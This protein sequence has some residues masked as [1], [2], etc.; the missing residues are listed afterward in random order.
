MKRGEVEHKR[1]LRWDDDV[2]RGSSIFEPAH[3]ARNERK[4]VISEC[5]DVPVATLGYGIMSSQL[6]DPTFPPENRQQARLWV[7]GGEPGTSSATLQ[8]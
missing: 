4:V 1:T 5:E 7:C 6:W 2:R 8:A 3:D